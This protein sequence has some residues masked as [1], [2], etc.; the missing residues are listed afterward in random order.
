MGLQKCTDRPLPD[1][2]STKDWKLEFMRQHLP[3]I[4]A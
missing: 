4:D 2:F 1:V 3:V